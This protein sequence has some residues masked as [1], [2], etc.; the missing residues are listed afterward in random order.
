MPDAAEFGQQ[1]QTLSCVCCGTEAFDAA[2][3]CAR[4]HVPLELSR[5][6]AVRGVRPSFIPVFGASGAGK[7]V[8]IG[9]LLD[10]LSKGWGGV[11]GVPN[12]A[13]TVAVQQVAIAALAS[14]RFPEKTVCEAEDWQW[15][16][17]ELALDKSRRKYLDL[18]TPD[19][20]GEAIEAEI[21]HPGSFPAIK[22]C[23]SRAAA[24]VLLVDAA[25][26][27]EHARDEDFFATKLAAYIYQQ[28]VQQS[29]SPTTAPL[30]VPLAVTLT[31]SDQ[32]HEAEG[33]AESYARH[34][35]PSL[36]GYCDRYFTK[37]RYFAASAVGSVAVVRDARQGRRAIPLHVQ[38][39]GIV[40]PVAWIV[41]Q[42]R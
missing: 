20:A 24:I 21:E 17:C 36:T 30:R 29:R 18:V 19:L 38:P 40:D 5:C 22:S 12:N 6:A 33:D 37:C 26:L 15:V 1:R 41:K 16:H 23:V 3:C 14:R 34:H 35:L 39:R 8:Y 4:C 25:N 28:S 27:Q 11:T 9:L 2:G 7:T 13:F 42:L 32:C 31:K 10:M